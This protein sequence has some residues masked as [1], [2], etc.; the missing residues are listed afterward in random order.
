MKKAFLLAVAML[1]CL[2]VS[3][4]QTDLRNLRLTAR[5]PKG[6]VIEGLKLQAFLSRDSVVKKL[7]RFGNMWLKVSDSD[8]LTVVTSKQ[9]YVFPLAGRD[10]LDLVFKGMSNF[11]GI[12]TGDDVVI[13]VGYGTISAENDTFARTHLIVQDTDRDLDIYSYIVSRVPGVTLRGGVLLVRGA[14]PTIVV[15]GRTDYVDI[16]TLRPQDIESIAVLKDGSAA[17]YHKSA[18]AIVITTKFHALQRD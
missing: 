15:D 16:S 12:R 4:Q 8:T 6:K 2:A 17:I 1:L 9:I 11:Q 10:T 14:S 7:D 5:N 3:A 18:A 13:D